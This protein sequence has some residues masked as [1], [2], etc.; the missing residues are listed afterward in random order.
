M[1]V[2][3]ISSFS[4]RCFQKI[5]SSE[6]V[7]TR[8]CFTKDLTTINICSHNLILVQWP[9]SL[10]FDD[11]WSTVSVRFHPCGTN[12]F[13]SFIG[14]RGCLGF[15]YYNY[16]DSDRN[17]NDLWQFF[18]IK[19]DYFTVNETLRR[20]IWHY[21]DHRI[22][23]RKKIHSFVSLNREIYFELSLNFLCFL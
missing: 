1:L 6:V 2:N 14:W 4:P 17:W 9:F 8:A 10:R 13:S 20:T 11:F 21:N 5:F 22:F 19:A 15:E 18:H 12:S 3:S 23:K 7:K 16:F